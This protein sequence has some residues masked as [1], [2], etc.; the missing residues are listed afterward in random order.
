[1]AAATVMLIERDQWR[2]H[3]GAALFAVLTLV[4]LAAWYVVG[5]LQ[6]GLWLG[7]SSLP[8][9]V[10]GSVAAAII[11]FE[12]LLWPRKAL[13]RYRLV[14]TKYW[15]SAHLWFGLVCLPLGVLHSGFHWGGWLSTWLLLILILTVLSGLVGLVLQNI[16]PRTMLRQLPLETIHSQIDHVSRSAV[17]DAEQLLASAYGPRDMVMTQMIG[18]MEMSRFQELLQSQ[19]N[20]DLTQVIRIGAPRDA[21][22]RGRFDQPTGEAGPQEDARSLWNAY[23]ELKPF[24]LDGVTR[25]HLFGDASRAGGWFNLLRSACSADSQPVIGA[26]EQLAEQRRQFNCQRRLHRWLHA[27][28]PVHIGLSVALCVLLVTHIVFALRY[29]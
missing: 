23:D 2:L 28:L 21:L 13:R 25:V 9:L 17:Q 1:M 20:N 4:G 26:L 5:S 6:A 3:A 7:G 29:W 16:I 14:R 10:L 18:S 24:L 8:G 12:M 19:A 11:L 27:W 22:Q 15:L